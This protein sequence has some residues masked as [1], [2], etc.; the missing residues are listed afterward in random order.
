MRVLLPVLVAALAACAS[1]SPPP[2][3]PPADP[4]P[5]ASASPTPASAASAADEPPAGHTRPLDLTSACPHDMHLYFGDHPGDGQGQPGIVASGAT[6]P[7]PRAAD[8][9]QVVWVVDDKGFGLASVHITKH[10]RHIR[11]DAAC[12]KLDADSTR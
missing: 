11:I 12:T 10:M 2:A 8:G 9:T 7:V 5:P 6:I 1:A 4:G 3:A